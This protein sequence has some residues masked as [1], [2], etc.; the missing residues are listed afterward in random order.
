MQTEKART[1]TNFHSHIP[2]TFWLGMGSTP[3][4]HWVSSWWARLIEPIE[5]L[6]QPADISILAEMCALFYRDAHI[7]EVWDMYFHEAEIALQMV[8]HGIKIYAGEVVMTNPPTGFTKCDAIT[9]TTRLMEEFQNEPLIQVVMGYIGP[10][11]WASDADMSQACAKLAS[12]L[13]LPVHTHGAGDE[14]DYQ[15]SKELYGTGPIEALKH[16]GFFDTRIPKIVIAHCGFLDQRE[17]D[18]LTEMRDR[19]VVALC[20]RAARNLEYHKCPVERLIERGVTVGIGTDGGSP[21]GVPNMEEEI[22]LASSAYG[23]E[24]DYFRNVNHSDRTPLGPVS[25]NERLRISRSWIACLGDIAHRSGLP[26][27]LK[28]KIVSNALESLPEKIRLEILI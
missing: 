8:K 11:S 10:Y 26:K 9:E 16:F 19:V 2:M 28:E 7:T 17:V 14:G 15:A 23:V 6:L 4:T 12:E 18:I 27:E 24:G 3:G 22:S 20:P 21:S 5:K 1:Y 25:E 13:R